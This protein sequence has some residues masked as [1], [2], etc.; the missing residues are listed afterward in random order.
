MHQDHFSVAERK[1]FQRGVELPFQPAGA[2]LGHHR[3]IGVVELLGRLFGPTLQV[4]ARAVDG[5][6]HQPGLKQRPTPK[7]VDA[8]EGTDKNVLGDVFGLVGAA[9]AA[10]GVAVHKP[11]MVVVEVTHRLHVARL[12]ALDEFFIQVPQHDVFFR[13]G[14]FAKGCLGRQKNFVPAPG[15]QIRCAGVNSAMNKTTCFTTAALAAFLSTAEAAA[16]VDRQLPVAA[17]AEVAVHSIS[18]TAKIRLWDKPQVR[19]Q[20]TSTDA[21]K[22]IVFEKSATGVVIRVE[23]YKDQNGGSADL[24]L[25]VPRSAALRVKGVNLAVDVKSGARLEVETVNGHIEADSEGQVRLQTVNGRITVR[26]QRLDAS[27][28][29]VNGD[30]T[31]SAERLLRLSAKSVGGG[32]KVSA[33]AVDAA[34][35]EIKVHSGRVELRLPASVGVHSRTMMAKEQLGSSEPAAPSIDVKSFSGAVTLETI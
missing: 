28:Q 4:R 1:F 15:N 20:A 22:E 27:L 9:G 7:T 8:F 33:A 3:Q 6:A 26:G 10:Q 25:R 17:D 11:H 23:P 16:P 13:L 24:I 5:D 34:R 2:L 30:I 35:H 12:G 32:V 19:L 31:V 14:P 29:T 18:G 21:I